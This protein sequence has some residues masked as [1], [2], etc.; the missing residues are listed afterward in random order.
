MEH[1]QLDSHK[2]EGKVLQTPLNS[3]PM[4]RVSWLN[5]KIPELLWLILLVTNLERE[6][7]IE[8]LRL[9]IAELKKYVKPTSTLTDITHSILS[10]SQWEFGIIMGII[11]SNEKYIQAVSPLSLLKNISYYSE[12]EI[13]FHDK[14]LK[15]S[16]ILWQE[17]GISIA[18]VLDHQSQES[19]DCRWFRLMFYLDVITRLKGIPDDIKEE[20]EKYPNLWDQRKVRPFIRSFEVW[21]W[22]SEDG[23]WEVFNHELGKAFRS[24]CLTNSSCIPLEK[25]RKLKSSEFDTEVIINVLQQLIAHYHERIRTTS[26]DS[27]F[28]IT[29]WIVLYVLVL[30]FDMSRGR[31]MK[32]TQKAIL[33]IICEARITLKYLIVK[34]DLWDK[35]RGYWVG[36]AKLSFLKMLKNPSIPSFIDQS[37]LE[38][39]IS[40]DV[41]S[42]F[43]DINIWH[44]CWG[45]LRDMSMTKGVWLKWEYD[46]YYDWSSAFIHANWWALRETCFTKC[47]NP[48]HRLH[49]IPQI[50][51]ER[52]YDTID[53]MIILVNKMLDDLD[54]SYPEFKIR[55]PTI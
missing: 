30:L 33:R 27:Q 52:N 45:N 40:E 39:F 2:H 3:L 41:W 11:S 22:M 25:E 55:I 37:F 13:L 32:A 48:L 20:F 46:Q 1:S 4:T 23:M 24:F 28:E 36:E 14:V 12:W 17:L 44:R 7:A 6:E 34:G 49:N 29:F 54:S 8:C 19:T 38:A 53:D 35:F 43:V 21:L 5:D 50:D 16:E 9:L 51:S 42:E 18:K 10:K 26:L 47:I 15:D 31:N